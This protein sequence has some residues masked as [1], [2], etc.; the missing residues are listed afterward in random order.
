MARGGVSVGWAVVAGKS[1]H[2]EA[3]RGCIVLCDQVLPGVAGLALRLEE[4]R[5]Y[6][7]VV[8][9]R[10]RSESSRLQ[11]DFCASRNSRD[12]RLR[13]TRC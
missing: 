4:V 5:A 10:F 1:R 6:A 11:S 12:E 3:A 8:A 13:Q 9:I 2:D 7:R